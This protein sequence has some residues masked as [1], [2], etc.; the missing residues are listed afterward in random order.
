MSEPFRVGYPD[1]NIQPRLCMLNARV[2][3]LKSNKKMKLSINIFSFVA[4]C[5]IT[6]S[7]LARDED[8]KTEADW[9]EEIEVYAK[10]V[11]L[12]TPAGTYAAPVTMLRFD[13]SIEVQIRGLAE[14]QADVTV[15]GGLFENTGFK[16]GPVTIVDPQTGHYAVELPVDP[17]LLSAPV[18]QTGISNA[19]GGFNS[20]IATVA[21]GIPKIEAGGSLR[22]GVGSDNLHNESLRAAF[23]RS[24]TEGRHLAI[25]G[26]VAYSEGDGSVVNGDHAFERYNLQLQ[27][28]TEDTQTDIIFA[29]QDKFFGWPGAYTGFGTLAET[30][31]TQTM[32]LLATHRVQ[33][34]NAWLEVG[35]Y[36]R[37]LDDDYDF[38]RTTKESGAPGAFD[39]KTRV[40]GIG[41]HGAFYRR[42]WDWNYALQ[43]MSDELIRSTDLTE[44]R[45]DSRDYLTF[46]L[47]PSI[48]IADSKT[49]KVILTAGASVDIS[50][51][52]ND[53]A[54]PMFG[55]EFLYPTKTGS[56]YLKF[57]Y[58][59]NSQLPGYTALNSRP[60][61]LFGGNASLGRER[62]D[63]ASITL[64]LS[65]GK[66][67]TDLSIFYRRDR[68][69]VDWTYFSGAPFSRQANDV[70]IDVIGVK[71]LARDSWSDLNITAAYTFLDKDSNYGQTEMDASFYALNFARHR[72]TVALHYHLTDQI[73]LRLDN[74]YRLQ[75]KNPLRTSS[76]ESFLA[77]ASLTWVTKGDDGFRISCSADNLTDEDFQQFPGTPASGRQISL[78]V[79]YDW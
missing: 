75:E 24:E 45:F 63:Q 39:H 72:M 5:A 67:T 11:A 28:A 70:N 34:D 76:E 18:V 37:Q 53:A 74:E 47:T 42:N 60:A 1:Y 52:D 10:R 15:Q 7:A 68:D 61:G 57:E 3:T 66:R 31:H 59:G 55:L 29:Y 25:Q 32:L 40:Y 78:N 54:S 30:D 35:G 26:S 21:Y 36:F 4:F 9:I 13:P 8:G 20:S 62:A 41:V 16:I 69:L 27:R 23:L 71:L 2:S 79:Q 44:G 17:A 58:A 6:I 64:G 50:N 12:E 51:R 43:M 77:S 38:D 65:S 19:I 56:R 73:E 46:S 48:V 22:A 14:G 49:N 33:T